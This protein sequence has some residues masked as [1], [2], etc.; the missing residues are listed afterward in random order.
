MATDADAA[1]RVARHGPLILAV[2]ILHLTSQDRR[3]KAAAVEMLVFSENTLNMMFSS[4]VEQDTGFLE[5]Q[6]SMVLSEGGTVASRAH[7]F[8]FLREVA[9]R[10]I[11]L[12]PEVVIQMAHVATSLT[13]SSHSNLD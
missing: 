11:A 2:G 1:E 4:T 13:R 12:T 7:C 8:R 6:A 9:K 10:C 3:V 5:I